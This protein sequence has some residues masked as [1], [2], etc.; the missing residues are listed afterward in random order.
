MEQEFQLLPEQVEQWKTG[1]SSPV[2]LMNGI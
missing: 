1:S 2:S